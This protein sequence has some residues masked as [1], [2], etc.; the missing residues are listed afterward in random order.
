[1][2]AEGFRGDVVGYRGNVHVNA[3]NIDVTISLSGASLAIRHSV[4]FF[5]VCLVFFECR[6]APFCC[7]WEY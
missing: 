6:K 7:K 3:L 2:A 5:F 1:M 4:G